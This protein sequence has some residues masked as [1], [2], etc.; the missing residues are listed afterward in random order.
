M[1][2]LFVNRSA[3]PQGGIEADVRAAA[4]G[5]GERGHA[6][7]LLAF[8][9]DVDADFCAPFHSVEV[10]VARHADTLA[11]ATAELRPDVVYLHKVEDASRLHLGRLGPPV[12]RFVHDHD[13]YCMRRHRYLPVTLSLCTRPADVVGCLRCGGFVER[14]RGGPLPFRWRPVTARL[15]DLDATAALARVLVAS[16]FMATELQR[17]GLPDSLVRVV[18]LGVPDA[19]LPPPPPTAGRIAC[20]GQVLRTK[21][22]DLLLQALALLPPSVTV[23]VVGDGPQRPEFE[24]LSD[25]LGLGPRV[26]WHGRLPAAAVAT[27]MSDAAIVALPARW[28]EPFGLVGV[29]AM[30][31]SRPV[32]AFDVGGIREWLDP[33]RTG[34]LAAPGSAPSLAAALDRLTSRP[35]VA[36]SMGNMGRAAFDRTFR[37]DRYL[38]RLE[39]QLVEVVQAPR[40]GVA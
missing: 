4:A 22:L 10:A 35:E 24:A 29:E 20:V 13:L 7:H 2:I 36:R 25:R 8:D 12:V 34:L 9:P 17:N 18:P 15:H 39:R 27:I 11:R 30:R 26:T 3:R 19:E 37:M 23:D 16:R 14:A 31:A 40:A 1:R 32:V 5:L 6:C 21:G 33:E 38:D 28:P